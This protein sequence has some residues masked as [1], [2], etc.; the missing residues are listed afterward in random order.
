M[1]RVIAVTVASFALA[2]A[3]VAVTVAQA[4]NGVGGG[5]PQECTAVFN[6]AT[7]NFTVTILNFGQF[8]KNGPPIF[9]VYTTNHPPA[10][11]TIE[12]STTT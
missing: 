6:P 11:C 7:G 2:T 9:K 4:S 1:K 3:G 12:T 10:S 5:G 8:K